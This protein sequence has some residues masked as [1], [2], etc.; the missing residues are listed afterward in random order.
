VQDGAFLGDAAG[1]KSISCSTTITVR[2]PARPP[3]RAPRCYPS[4]SG[5]CGHVFVDEQDL[6]VPARGACR[7]RA[8]LVAVREE[9]GAAMGGVFKPVDSSAPFDELFLGAADSAERLRI[10]RACRRRRARGSR[11]RVTVEDGWAAGTC[12][13]RRA[14]RCATRAWLRELD[15]LASR[16]NGPRSGFRFAGD[17]SMSVVLPAPFGPMMQRSSPW[18]TAR[19]M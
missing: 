15:F 13:R 19:V 7:S 11:R 14:A 18:S 5:S 9:P 17:T 6:R 2:S 12:G 8:L 16:V 10:R 4:R 1:T 3:Q